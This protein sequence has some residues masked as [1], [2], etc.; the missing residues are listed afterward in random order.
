MLKSCGD[1]ESMPNK[2]QKSSTH[3]MDKQTQSLIGLPHEQLVMIADYLPK[4]SRALL[5][6]ALTAPSKSFRAAWKGELS[7]PAKVVMSSLKPSYKYSSR[8]RYANSN[9]FRHETQS[10]K[11][12]RERL[13]EYYE[14]ASWEILDTRDIKD[15]AKKLTDDDIGA[16]LVCIDAKNKLQKLKLFN[17]QKISGVGLESLHKSMML[18]EIA[19]PNPGKSM[20]KELLSSMINSILDM[21]GHSLRKLQLPIRWRRGK[22]RNESPVKE[23]LTRFNEMLVNNRDVKCVQCN[24]EPW[25]YWDEDYEDDDPF[26][27]LTCFTCFKSICNKCIEGSEASGWDDV[28]APKIKNCNRCNLLLC[29]D[30]GNHS[31]CQSCKSCFCSLCAKEEGVDAAF[32]CHDFECYP[33]CMGCSSTNDSCK[34]CHEMF[35]SRLTKDHKRQA[36]EIKRLNE[37]VASLREEVSDLRASKDDLG[38]LAA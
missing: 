29:N 9:Q 38:V 37:E 27:H 32:S 4:T 7:D 12:E 18:E 17:C 25:L 33:T 21:D 36:K 23:V 15:L 16:I 10:E 34:E 31:E 3:I 11:K 14:L 5:A 13:K 30:C 1:N 35:V 8:P 6:V 2:R 28:D 24:N 26:F 22:A 20:S 19:A